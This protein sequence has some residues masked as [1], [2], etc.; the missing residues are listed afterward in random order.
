MGRL[1][2]EKILEAILFAAGEAVPVP[3][4]AEALEC[5]IPAVRGLLARMA[6]R[7]IEEES[8]II[9]IEIEDSFQMCTNPIYYGYAQR[10]LP[11]RSARS[12]TMPL[13]ETLAIVAYKQPVTKAVIEGIRGVNA[14]HTVNK[15]VEYGLVEECGRLDAPGRP[16]LFGTTEGFLRYY[17]IRT[18]E[19]FLVYAGEEPHSLGN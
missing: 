12:L 2:Q 8:G 15:L 14:D 18:V 11:A 19:E 4:L 13:L 1:E 9:L 3:R 17:G 5:P 10:L 16:I 7:Y 6:E